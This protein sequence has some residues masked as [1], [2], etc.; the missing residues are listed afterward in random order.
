METVLVLP[1]LLGLLA[2]VFFAASNIL[3]RAGIT[4]SSPILAL[5]YSLTANV[6]V[7]WPLVVW[8]YDFQVDLW[9]WRYFI[10]AGT[11][12]P[13]LGRFFNYSGI[14]KLGINLS[15][16]ITYTNPLVTIVLATVFLGQRLLPLGYVGAVVIFAGSVLLGT[17]R[18]ESGVRTFKKRH[19]IFPILASLFYGG[20]HIFREVGIELVSS[21]A[22]AAAVTAST[23]WFWMV[24]YLVVTR[25]RHDFA[26]TRREQIFFTL[27]GVAT[28]TAI[29]ILYTALQVGDVVIVAP[30]SNMTPFWLLLLSFVFFRGSELFTPRVIGGTLLTVVG[31][32]LISTFGTVS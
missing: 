8:L 14:D 9:A 32:I 27:S 21:P 18:G 5:L 15:T 10:V 4:D 26:I 13:V 22:L 11:L 29:P 31:V 19:L 28:A 20:S 6:V 23:S 3:V 30:M 2:A 1:V 12:A 16:P 24:L 17:T 25:H 7:L